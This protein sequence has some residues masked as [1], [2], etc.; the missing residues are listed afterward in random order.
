MKKHEIVIYSPENIVKRN[1]HIGNPY[2]ESNRQDFKITMI[3]M[4]KHFW[5]D[6]MDERM[7]SFRRDMKILK[8]NQM[9]IIKLK[10]LISE[11]F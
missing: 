5:M 1:R 2:V 8:N 9:G 10:I 7:G 3:N 11:I 6:T 4:L